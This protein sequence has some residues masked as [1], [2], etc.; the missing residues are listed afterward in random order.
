MNL[1]SLIFAVEQDGDLKDISSASF[2]TFS[3]FYI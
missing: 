2:S 1:F 3:V